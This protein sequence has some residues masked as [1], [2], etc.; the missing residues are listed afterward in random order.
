MVLGKGLWP[1]LPDGLEPPIGPVGESSQL[2]KTKDCKTTCRDQEVQTGIDE[3]G[4]LAV[5]CVSIGSLPV[6]ARVGPVV[7]ALQSLE[8][9]RIAASS[10]MDT[11][12]SSCLPLMIWDILP[13]P[14][15]A[16]L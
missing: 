5:G 2:L 14:S 6:A 16:R 8:S 3:V 12:R 7:Q 10:V 1:E 13:P 15:L 9:I 4:V 11:A